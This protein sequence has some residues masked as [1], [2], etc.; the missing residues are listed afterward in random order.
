MELRSGA[1]RE[2]NTRATVVELYQGLAAASQNRWPSLRFDLL[3][4]NSLLAPFFGAGFYYKTFMWPSAFWEKLYEPAIRRA[5][6]LGPRVARA[7]PDRYEKAWAHCDVL[8]IGAGPTGLMAALAAGR[9]GARVILA[10]EDFR[11]GGRL[12]SETM[13]IGGEPAADWAERRSCRAL[14]PAECAADAPHHRVRRL[15]RQHLRRGRARQRSRRG[16]AGVRAAPARLAHRGQ[17]CRAGRRRARAADDVC[18][19][20]SARHHAGVRRAHLR[21]SLRRRSGPAGGRARLVRR[22]LAHGGGPDGCRRQRRSA[23][24]HARERATALGCAWRTIAGGTVENAHGGTA[25]RSDRARRNRAAARHRLRPA[26][27]VE[28]LEPDAAPYLPPRRRPA[29]N[30][31]AHAFVPASTPARHDGRRR[32]RGPLLPARVSRRWCS[33]RRASGDRG[34]VCSQPFAAARSRARVGARSRAAVAQA[35]QRR[36]GLPRLPERRDRQRRRA[37]PS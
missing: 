32:S 35:R 26:R 23:G 25:C 8:V 29:W 5:A 3:A 24:R 20:R 10:E 11:L 30:E 33:A 31:A 13:T 36:Q 4:V 14:L 18:R 37:R 27:D 1:R 9:A 17:A 7:D 34:R 19:Q 12:L 21:Q 2:P 15:R 28:R 16:A 22:R 6:G